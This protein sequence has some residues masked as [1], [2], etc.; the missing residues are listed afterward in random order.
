MNHAMI[1]WMFF[2][3]W[4]ASPVWAQDWAAVGALP[5]DTPVRVVSQSGQVHGRISIVEDTQLTVLTRG[6]PIVIPRSAIVR[7]EHER[8][9]PLWNGMLIGALASLAMRVAFAGEACSRTPEPRCTVQGIL[10]GTGLG[11]FIDYQIRR[12]PVIYAAPAPSL[13]LLRWSF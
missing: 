9:D 6:K 4:S 5:V 2:V 11:A 1:A 13:T 7:L 12:Y 8:R 3:C 10:V